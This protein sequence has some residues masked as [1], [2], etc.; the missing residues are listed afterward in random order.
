M[1]QEQLQ[2]I[3]KDQL[4]TKRG[5]SL[6]EV[7]LASSIFILI[8]T[9][10]SG[11]YL[12]GQESTVLAG[13]RAR[14]V[15][16]A[17][18]GLEA[19]RNIRD[20][21]FSNL[22]DGTYGLAISGNEWIFSGG[23]DIN[24][25]FTREIEI[26]TIDSSRKVVTSTISWQQNQQRTGLVALTTYFTDWARTVSQS[27]GFVVATTSASIGGGGDKEL[28]D[29]TIENTGTTDIVID[30][31]TVTWDNGNLI[32]EIRIDNTRVWR[33]NNEGTPD[34]RQVSGTEL[35][36]EDFTLSVGS[37]VF[38]IDKI[39]FDDDMTGSVFT[40]LFTFSDS[41]TSLVT[42]DL[43]GGGGGPVCGTQADDLVID[44]SGANIGGG[45]N[46]ELRD[47]T[48]EN[49]DPSC[50]IVIDKITT[51][52]TNGQ[53]IEEIRIEGNR[54][55]KHN[56]EGTPNGKQ[57]TGI[58]LDNVDYTVLSGSTDTFNKFKFNGNMT[59]DTFTITFEMG[60]GSSK[61]TVSFSP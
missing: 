49:T 19:T 37:G 6:I 30:K 26:G 12:Y 32:E 42:I 40:I 22:I 52:W 60:D 28:Q 25:V 14:A 50:D 38:D 35:D 36:I 57:S 9:A 10:F 31:I 21:S 33:H 27:K 53:L 2:L 16:L 24:G 39:K 7:I 44:T 11:A 46:K 8:V 1:K 34:G 58:E 61:S 41:S 5:F 15:F 13:N 48:V 43:S 56:N 3:Q 54:I 4:N 47:V 20:E 23:S 59:G 29:V 51:T 55:W 18:E 45:G 17:E